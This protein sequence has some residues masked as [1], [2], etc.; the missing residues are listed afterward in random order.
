[1]KMMHFIP[2][3]RL[4]YMAEVKRFMNVVKVPN[5]LT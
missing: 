4:H 5:Q 1:M 3:I 2:V